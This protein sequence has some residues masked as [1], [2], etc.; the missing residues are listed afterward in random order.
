VILEFEV[1]QEKYKK[2]LVMT[3]VADKLTVILVP[4]RLAPFW[5]DP[6][7]VVGSLLYI[8]LAFSSMYHIMNSIIEY[9]LDFH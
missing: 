6:I 4:S 2:I 9:I 7:Q 5:P 3:G 8:A 1:L